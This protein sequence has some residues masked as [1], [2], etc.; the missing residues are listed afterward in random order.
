MGT[1]RVWRYSDDEDDSVVQP[2][3]SWSASSLVDFHSASED[4]Y[5]L[6]GHWDV[7]TEPHDGLEARMAKD[8]A[9]QV[10]DVGSGVNPCRFRSTYR[11][12]WL[13]VD[14]PRP[15][16]GQ[17]SRLDPVVPDSCCNLQRNSGVVLLWLDLAIATAFAGVVAVP[18]PMPPSRPPRLLRLLLS[19]QLDVVVVLIES[20]S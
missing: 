1:L 12:T 9:R 4:Y 11:S 10:T 13:Y 6:V 16:V 15:D 8:E 17:R 19:L 14:V 5:G 18:R 3:C 7:D 2:P 20:E